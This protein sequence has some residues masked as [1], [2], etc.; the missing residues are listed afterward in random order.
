MESAER[1]LSLPVGCVFVKCRRRG[2]MPHGMGARDR[3]ET[4]T[5]VIQAFSVQRTWTQAALAREVGVGT[6]ALRR[7]IL[8]LEAAGMRLER[9]DEH[10]HVYWSVPKGWFPGGVVFDLDDWDV[11]VHAVLGISD[12]SRRQKLL[13][14]LLSGRDSGPAMRDGLER[15][16]Q[17]VT[18][19]PLKPEESESVLM[20]ERAIL[21]AVPLAIH[22]YS[23]SRGALG[24]RVVSPQKL[25]T[26]RLRLAAH[27]HSNGV[28]RWFRVDNI[29]RVRLAPEEQWVEV[30]PAALDAFLASSVD[31][32]RDG[33]K[34]DL[35]FRVEPPDS[36]W[37]RRN[38]LP[39]MEAEEAPGGVLRVT[40]RGAAPVVAR[41][42]VG[43][44]G[45]AVA[46][47]EDLRALVREVAQRTLEVHRRC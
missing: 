16:H 6:P 28:L 43:L 10:P 9:E 8:N 30:E 15:L 7:I 17:A 34:Q 32:F 5:R 14:R 22:Y 35:V 42:I 47:G 46:E 21:K 23:A 31:G 33:T 25:F 13:G 24:W 40:A 2:R 3:Y 45:S 39:G 44:G 26:E 29:Q 4:I 41:F 19:T 37:V 20:I 38:L 12:Q 11:L 36:H 1:A 27:C 18:A